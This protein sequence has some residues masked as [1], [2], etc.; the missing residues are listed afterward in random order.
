MRGKDKCGMII[1]RRAQDGDSGT[2]SMILSLYDNRVYT[3][4]MGR[5]RGFARLILNSFQMEKGLF[6]ND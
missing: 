4:F 3:E 5:R 2:R 1:S 6:V